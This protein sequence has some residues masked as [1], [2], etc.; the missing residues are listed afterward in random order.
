MYL[1]ERDLDRRIG[2]SVKAGKDPLDL[3]DSSKPDYAGTPEALARYRT[4]VREAVEESARRL[5][6]AAASGASA[7]P[8]PVP[9]RLPGETA[10]DWLQR[11]GAP[12]PQAKPHVPVSR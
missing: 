3:F 12:L 1:L 2:Q 10:A 5:Q 7:A 8:P 4:T 11:T 6:P 9:P